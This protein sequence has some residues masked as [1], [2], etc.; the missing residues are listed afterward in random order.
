MRDLLIPWWNAY[1]FFVTYA[2]VDKFEESEVAA[3]ESQNVLDRWIVSSIET[4][5]ADVTAAMDAYDLQKAV[6]PFVKFVE[7][8]TNW[9]IR[10]SRRRFWKSQ[11]DGDKLCAYR[12]LRYALVQLSKVAAPFTPFIA[13]E[14]YRNLRGAADPESVHLCD[15]PTSNA[16]ARD[17]ALE[18][19]MA[20]VQT[21]VELGRR[22]RADND[23]KVR[24]PLSAIKVA[25]AEFTGGA[26]SKAE[27]EAL[28][29]DELNIKKVIWTSD[30]TELCDISYKANF[31]S[32]GPKCGPKMKSVAAAIAKGGFGEDKL[33][34]GSVEA[35]EVEGVEVTRADV[36]VTRSPKAGLVVASQDAVVVGIE[37][38]LTPELIAEGN[39]R[40][41]VSHVQNMR[42]EA[43]FEVTQRIS[44]TVDGDEDMRTALES[45]R[46]YVMS[47][48]LALELSFGALEGFQETDL[49]G[50]VTRIKVEKM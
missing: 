26:A 1:S 10:R 46:E 44:V 4:L 36:L 20:S 17:I 22:L 12:T 29:L 49:N 6:R 16:S 15:F 34:G 50:H 41:F 13:D 43:D 25:G 40:E 42:K 11:N 18:R 47:E 33:F 35:V 32:L 23:L 48:I 24:Q 21:V 2:N 28:I 38:A 45:H 37:T 9:Y 31:K 39:A 7:D 19:S 3:P 8:L 30:E 27:L 14:I 5:I